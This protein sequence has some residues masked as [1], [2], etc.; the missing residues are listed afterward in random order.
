MIIV[1]F[2]L[3]PIVFGGFILLWALAGELM[4]ALPVIQTIFW[5]LFAIVCCGGLWLVCS[6]G[7]PSLGHRLCYGG[8]MAGCLTFMGIV[9][10]QFFESMI[11]SYGDG[12]LNGFFELIFAVVGGSIVWLVC[13]AAA[14]YVA[15]G[16]PAGG[17]KEFSTGRLVVSLFLTAGLLVLAL[18]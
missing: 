6:D 2:D 10:H 13:F 17:D 4:A 8:I 18:I 1:F 7:Y 9:S 15:L 14:T 5:I 3:A 16:I 11:T 12:G